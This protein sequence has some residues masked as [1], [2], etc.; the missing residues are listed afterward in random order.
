MTSSYKRHNMITY[1]C[2]AQCILFLT[3]SEK[4]R[5]HISYV[6]PLCSP[7]LNKLVNEC[8][9]STSSNHAAAIGSKWPV[10]TQPKKSLSQTHRIS[11]HSSKGRT[12]ITC[13]ITQ[14]N[15]KETFR[16]N[17]QGQFLHHARNI[18]PVTFMPGIQH[19]Q[20][21]LYHNISIVLD[22][23]LMKSRLDYTSLLAV[24]VPI[25]CQQAIAD[26]FLQVARCLTISEV[27]CILCKYITY[28]LWPEKQ[29]DRRLSSI[30]CCHITIALL[31][32]LQVTQLITTKAQ[33]IAKNG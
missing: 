1:L 29:Y 25:D 3:R 22:A 20:C 11:D 23:F 8:I 31:H 13:I 4:H 5:K 10:D 33:K 26:Q 19:F 6:L 30:K 14:I 32:L 21:M 9:N 28:M 16:Y 18:H 12:K 15:I 2:I 24:H 17:T 27:A 7:P